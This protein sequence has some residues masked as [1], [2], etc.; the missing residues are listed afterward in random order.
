MG[1]NVLPVA[2]SGGGKTQYRVQLTSGSSWT[3]PA[4]VTYVNVLL[5]GGGSTGGAS[6][7]AV[8][9]ARGFGGECTRSLV[10]TTPG[11]SISY[12]IGAGAGGGIIGYS[13]PPA[14]GGTTSF[15]G[16]TDARGG[17]A[18]RTSFIDNGIYP[19]QGSY[20]TTIPYAGNG[21]IEIEYWA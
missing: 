8:G 17:A 9:S 14:T 12:T 21:F 6:Q 5:V 18:G 15:T 2:S 10:L 20:Y 13:K 7:G 19:V 1:I 16:A 3:V 11:Q 4:G